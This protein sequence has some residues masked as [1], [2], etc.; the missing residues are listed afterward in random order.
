MNRD[1]YLDDKLE[2]EMLSERR[3]AAWAENSFYYYKKLVMTISDIVGIDLTKK[4][5]LDYFYDWIQTYYNVDSNNIKHVLALNNGYQDELSPFFKEMLTPEEKDDYLRR[6]N[7]EQE[8]DEY[9][10]DYDFIVNK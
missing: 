9:I 2:L 8:I 4:E 3:E 6:Q 1:T 10:D 7:K 5:N